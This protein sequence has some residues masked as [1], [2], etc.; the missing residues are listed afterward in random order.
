MTPMGYKPAHRS[1]IA[2]AILCALLAACGQN[3]SGGT[4]G[5]GAAA[6]PKPVDAE[7]EIAE[8]GAPA[9]DQVKSLYQGSFEAVGTEPFWRL[10]LMDDWVSFTR[11]GLQEV[12]GLPARKD[13]RAN[14]ARIVAGPLVIT[15]RVAQCEHETGETLPYTAEVDYEGVSYDGCARRGAS[16]SDANWAARITDVLPAIDSCLARIDNKP[17]R[18]TIAYLLDNG[19]A[20]VRLVDAQGGRYEC[21]VNSKGGQVDDWG[22]LS[23]RDVMQGEGDPIFSR[24][25][26]PAPAPKKPCAKSV[27]AKAPDGRVLGW[28][29]QADC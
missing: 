7:K 22:A 18:V 24:A 25:P 20:S 16:T 15:L 17:G 27:E 14:G 19:R 28:L 13:Y 2:A 12:G 23:D 10:D 11:P 4:G 9:T 21:S 6:G 8:L 29:T 5:I 26:T 1:A 3:S